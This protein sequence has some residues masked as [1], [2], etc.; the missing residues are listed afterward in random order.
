MN[1]E[2]DGQSDPERPWVR[3]T[4]LFGALYSPAAEFWRVVF[5]DGKDEPGTE[6]STKESSEPAIYLLKV[7]PGITPH[8]PGL[9]KRVPLQFA[10]QRL[11]PTQE[12]IR[13]PLMRLPEN[14]LSEETKA[15]RDR[16]FYVIAHLVS[17]ETLPRLLRD[18]CR[19]DLLLEQSEKVGKNISAIRKA[20]RRYWWFGCDSNAMIELR[21]RQGGPGK[22]RLRPAGPMRGRPN[23]LRKRDPTTKFSG[24]NYDDSHREKFIEAL[25][26]YWIGRGT[27]LAKAYSLMCENKYRTES[28]RKD[29]SVYFRRVPKYKIP[30]KDCFYRKTLKLRTDLSLR[31]RNKG[32][33]DYATQDAPRTGSARDIT[34]GPGDIFD[35]DATEFNFE[36]VASFDASLRVGK[37][38]VYTVADR[39]STC[40]VGL[41]LECRAER[42]EGYRRALYCAFAPKGA[43]VERL[44]LAEL[45]V[46]VFDVH[47]V[48]NGIF[49]DRGPGRSDLAVQAL[50]EEL[51]L[52]KHVPPPK[53]PYLNAVIE[54]LQGRLQDVLSYESGGYR[55]RRGQRA[56]TQ[57]ASAREDATHNEEQ[58]FCLLIAAADDHNKHADASH[59]LTPEMGKT[60]GVPE[61]I[62]K[63]GIK[64]SPVNHHRHQN[65]ADL[66]ARLLPSFERTVTPQGIPYEK[67]QYTSPSLQRWRLRQP[68]KTGNKIRVYVDADP[69]YL[70]W[71]PTPDSWEELEMIK[72]H[73]KRA[74]HMRWTDLL[75][76]FE[77][78]LGGK[79]KGDVRRHKE[80]VFPRVAEKM[81]RQAAQNVGAGSKPKAKS[82]GNLNV[83][84]TRG[85]SVQQQQA[86]Q[87]KEGRTHMATLVKPQPIVPSSVISKPASVPKKATKRNG[88]PSLRDL[89]KA[90]FQPLEK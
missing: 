41:Y 54:S 24:V 82:L 60:R 1:D 4:L 40:I 56:E 86:G 83:T 89:R 42:W 78:N 57:H 17:D 32:A 90:M 85:I 81:V 9:P 8:T 47:G 27:T 52:E 64:N 7:E 70:Y 13:T 48:P 73:Q 35:V 38:T 21:D 14:E 77:R 45:K 31:G 11:D 76:Y 29:G 79:I 30:S 87:R 61:Q 26:E 66:Y 6:P 37:P 5:V 62:F 44:D 51:G 74:K 39:A 63:W 43:L 23:V 19:Q 15:A 33:L 34:S 53:T 50:S 28:V 16:R 55:R 25:I 68:T 12:C 71:R 59:L 72:A 46:K 69:K 67:S 75:A 20:L 49:S 3:G 58:F 10:R 65:L 22:E 36:L 84:A 18:D 80:K 2:Q 88:E